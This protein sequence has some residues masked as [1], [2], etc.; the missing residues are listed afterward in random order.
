MP[1]ATSYRRNHWRWTRAKTLRR[2]ILAAFANRC[3]KCGATRKLQI[4]H[5]YGRDWHPRRVAY[6]YRWLRYYHEFLLHLIDVR[7][8]KC[9]RAYK[10]LPPPDP[11]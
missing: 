2:I 5:L 9:N 10:P 1:H 8:P 4:N 7:C 3:V 11:F 6:Y